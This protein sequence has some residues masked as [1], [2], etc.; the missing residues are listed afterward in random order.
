MEKLEQQELETLS[1]VYS[2]VNTIKRDIA[3]VSILE[4]RCIND[5]KRLMFDFSQ[6]NSEYMKM[7]EDIIAKYGNVSVNLQTGEITHNGD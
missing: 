6:A 5:K 2:K 3:D 4:E 1:S 7:Q